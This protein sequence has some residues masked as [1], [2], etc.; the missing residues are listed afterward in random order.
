MPRT[1]HLEIWSN[2]SQHW[3]II[4][5]FQFQSLESVPIH[6]PKS[7]QSFK[8]GDLAF[9]DNSRAQSLGLNPGK[10]GLFCTQYLVL[11]E[12]LEGSWGKHREI[13]TFKPALDAATRW[14]L[15]KESGIPVVC[16]TLT[17]F[18][19]SQTVTLHLWEEPRLSMQSP[20]K[21]HRHVPSS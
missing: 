13:W 17:T 10:G 3:D 20:G 5:I 21:R 19:I 16:C 1:R 7:N 12:G 4:F 11:R 9:R 18:P 2:S 8:L 15:W 14:L 6:A